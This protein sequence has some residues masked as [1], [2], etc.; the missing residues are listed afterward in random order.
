MALSLEN[1]NLVWQKAKISLESLGADSVT[2]AAMKALKEKLAGVG[3]N[4]DLQFVPIA[5]TDADDASG[6]V[7]ADVAC[8][9]YAVF[10]KKTATATDSYLSILDD[11]TD[12]TGV[13]TDVRAVLPFLEASHKVLFVEPD[14]LV[15]ATG[16]V[17]KAYTD[18]DGTTDSSAGDAPNGFAIIGAA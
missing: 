11:A 13:A 8:K 1:S 3:G 7:L 10:G 18:W 6:K 4:P 9:L 12:D 5:G 15:M 14:G 2:I 17:A 16:V